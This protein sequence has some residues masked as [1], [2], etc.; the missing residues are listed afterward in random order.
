MQRGHRAQAVE[1]REAALEVG[2]CRDG[3]GL[4]VTILGA[5]GRNH[6]RIGKIAPAVDRTL[7]PVPRDRGRDD[8]ARDRDAVIEEEVRVQR[9][10]VGPAHRLVGEALMPEVHT[11]RHEARVGDRSPA[12]EAAHTAARLVAEHARQQ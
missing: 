3:R 9:R 6:L 8:A 12:Q 2:P 7:E 4:G 10:A 1:A 11:E 5:S